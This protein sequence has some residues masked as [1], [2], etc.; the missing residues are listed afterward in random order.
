[1]PPFTP[2]PPSVPNMVPNHAPPYQQMKPIN[3]K[4][5]IGPHTETDFR[6]R[7]QILLQ[8]HHKTNPLIWCAGIMCFI[9][10]LLIILA[11]IATLVIFLAIKP[12]TPLFDTANASLN[13]IYLDSP[14]YYNGDLT[15][16]VNFTNPNQKI[17]FVFQYISLEM[18]LNNRL[19]SAQALPPFRQRSRETTI[20]AVHMV[21]SEVF[22][23]SDLVLHLQDQVRGN[24]VVYEIRGTFKVRS[25]FGFI[26]FAYWVYAR[27]EIEMSAPPRGVLLAKNCRTK[28]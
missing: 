16:L 21:S 19:V 2:S 28:Q 7:K 18:Y 8:S 27:C 3:N 17:N 15:L 10:S 11:G 4:P 1:M 9:F 22:L 26:H 12:R 13:S 25:T 24:R 6:S 23:P 5:L 20:Q 14:A